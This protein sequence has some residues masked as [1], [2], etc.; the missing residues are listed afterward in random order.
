MEETL[1]LLYLIFKQRKTEESES[2]LQ[3]D[4]FISTFHPEQSHFLGSRLKTVVPKV[5]SGASEA[6]ELIYKIYTLEIIM[7]KSTALNQYLA[8]SILFIYT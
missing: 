5:R 7:F 4:E 8:N 6:L 3:S 1:K 2:F